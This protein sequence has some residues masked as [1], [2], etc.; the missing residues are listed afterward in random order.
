M[1]EIEK[2]GHTELYPLLKEVNGPVDSF[3]AQEQIKAAAKKQAIE[4]GNLRGVSFQACLPFDDIDQKK[5]RQESV[6]AWGIWKNLNPDIDALTPGKRGL[7]AYANRIIWQATLVEASRRAYLIE[8]GQ[9]MDDMQFCRKMIARS[10]D[11]LYPK[12]DM[13]ITAECLNL[14]IPKIELLTKSGNGELKALTEDFLS[15][16]GFISKIPPYSPEAL[17]R[18]KAAAIQEILKDKYA[19]VFEQLKLEFPEINN[20]L[21]PQATSKFLELVGLAEVGEDGSR[22]GWT[23]EETTE[24][25]GFSTRSENRVIECGKRSKEITWPVFERLMVHEVGVHA[26]RAENGY[27]AGSELLA[28]GIGD[29]EDAEEG[30]AILFEKIW[31]G[32]ATN[33]NLVD[34]NDYRYL[35]AAYAVGAIDGQPHD[36][37]ATFLFI[38]KLDRLNLLANAQK[39]GEALDIEQATIEARETMF[40]HVYRA[41]RGMPEGSVM[42]KDML[43]KDGKIKLVGF[44]NENKLSIGELYGFLTSGKFDPTND[45]HLAIREAIINVK[46]TA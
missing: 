24:R 1:F 36:K 4:T 26:T 38:T 6:R 23:V 7:H 29:Y 12:P 3:K 45:E 16:Y 19:D 37:D 44:V 13:R 10:I 28:L 32:T 11:E 9:S 42:T 40:E 46:V 41:F 33:A 25:N 15:E 14:F 20:Q 22:T 35:V 21:L 43:Y 8:Q 27:Q 39:K 5:I 34:R 2:F 31:A 17:D 30:V 18:Q